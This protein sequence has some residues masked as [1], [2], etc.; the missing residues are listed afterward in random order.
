[1]ERKKVME[2]GV[3][4]VLLLVLAWYIETDGCQMDAG[5][6]I[7]RGKPGEGST[8]VNLTLSAEGLFEDYDYPLT[9]AET[10][11]TE[12]EA[13]KYF[14]QA[15]EEIDAG[16]FGEEEADRVTAAV[17]MQESYAGGMVGAD[18]S[19]D[20]YRVMSVDGR[21]A[22]AVPEAGELVNATAAL[23]CGRYREDYCF[24]FMVYPRAQTREEAL[25]SAVGTA[26]DKRQEA[27][28]EEYLAL[29]RTVN[30]YRLHWEETRK[31]LVWKTLF[32]EI[33]VLILL[34]F[35]RQE[36]E[37]EES[38]RRKEQMHLDYAEVVNKLLILLG[39]GMSLKQAWNRISAR[40]SEKREKRNAEP[41]FIYEEMLLASH[42]MADGESERLA[43]QNFGG[44][45]G[46]GA[47]NRLARILVQNLQTGSRGLCQLLQQEAQ[48]ALEDR[49][50]LTKKLGEEAGTKL[51]FPMILMLVIV[52]AII[53]VPAMLSF[54]A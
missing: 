24:G 15:K 7:A 28:G 52:I 21:V 10:A 25:L 36:R 22:E 37:R 23:S 18:W 27:E 51:L 39:S 16:F 44:R 45:T 12:E 14:A 13:E 9:V 5:G 40:Y 53:M 34:H 33:V 35:V 20:N 1:M 32:F 6:K 17:S 19:L 42:E 3:V 47:Y 8:D 46:L 4:C 29:P 50:A 26:I 43:Y 30:G 2:A 49:R 41:R 31:Y 11:I 38:R 54:N 48:T